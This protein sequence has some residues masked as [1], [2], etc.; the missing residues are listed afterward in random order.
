MDQYLSIDFVIG[1]FRRITVSDSISKQMSVTQDR[2]KKQA[3]HFE[4]NILMDDY[5]QS[6][7]KVN[8][9]NIELKR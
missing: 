2:L 6:H 1:V 7:S 3:V 5:R 8:K 9:L 4:F